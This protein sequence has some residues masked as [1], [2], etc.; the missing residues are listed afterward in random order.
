MHNCCL[1]AAATTTTTTTICRTIEDTTTVITWLESTL[2]SASSCEGVVLSATSNGRRPQI[3]L[4]RYGAYIWYIIY[5]MCQHISYIT[6]RGLY[7]QWVTV[8]ASLLTQQMGEL[9]WVPC[10]TLERRYARLGEDPFKAKENI[11]LISQI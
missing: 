10:K 11:K 1:P 3:Q 9:L 6:L 5:C 8:G 2:I 7:W 4:A